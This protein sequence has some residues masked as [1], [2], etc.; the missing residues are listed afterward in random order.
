M[1]GQVRLGRANLKAPASQYGWSGL[2][3]P[4]IWCPSPLPRRLGIRSW[5]PACLATATPAA[6]CSALDSLSRP[7][8]RGKVVKQN[9]FPL[10]LTTFNFFSL[11]RSLAILLSLALLLSC[12][13][14]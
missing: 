13:L 10:F 12:D 2:G 8:F 14:K 5:L 6:C 4:E 11:S 1:I 7:G 9:V 3:G